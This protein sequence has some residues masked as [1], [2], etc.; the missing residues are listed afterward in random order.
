MLQKGEEVDN[1]G[2]F[3]GQE[4]KGKK[5]YFLGGFT[6][7]GKRAVFLGVLIPWWTVC[8]HFNETNVAK[9]QTWLKTVN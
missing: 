3:C 4:S 8:H 1:I 7:T 6:S 5:L 2:G 9:A